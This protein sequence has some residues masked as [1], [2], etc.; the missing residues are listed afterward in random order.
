MILVILF[1]ASRQRDPPSKRVQF[2]PSARP[3]KPRDTSQEGP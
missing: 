2:I 3:T 1:P